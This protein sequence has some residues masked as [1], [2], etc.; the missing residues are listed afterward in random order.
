MITRA[1]NAVSTASNMSISDALAPPVLCS[2]HAV[3]AGPFTAP[4]KATP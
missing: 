4:N 2:P 1:N 3:A